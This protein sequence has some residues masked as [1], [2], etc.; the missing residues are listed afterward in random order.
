MTTVTIV[1]AGLMTGPMVNYFLDKCGYKIIMLDRYPELAEKKIR[2]RN[3][4]AIEWTPDKTEVLSKAVQKADFVISMLPKHLHIYVA[5]ACIKNKKNM[6]TSA[7]EIPELKV[8]HD[9]AKEKGILI[10]NELGEV[11][12]IDHYGTQLVLDRVRKKDGKVISLKSY[13]SSIPVMQDNPFSY[14]FAW[15]PKTFAVASQTESTYLLNGKKVKTPGN[16]LFEDPKTVK[17]KGLGT[18]ET[19]PNKDVTKYVK[20]FGLDENITFYRGLLRHPG[21]CKN[22]LNMLKLGLFKDRPDHDFSN[23]TY[24]KFMAFVIGKQ[25]AK[26]VEKEIKE[27]L[28]LEDDSFIKVLKWLGLL[29][30]EKIAIEKGSFVDVTLDKMIAK[31]SYKP[32]E[33]DM[34]MVHIEVIAENPEGEQFMETATLKVE[35]EPNGRESAISRAVALSVAIS[36][37]QFITGK[38]KATG[39]QMP[40]TLPE[41]C[42]PVLKEL[43]EY[44]FIF[45]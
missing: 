15:D 13:G 5:D 14:K 30:H 12:G 1:G 26:D 23:M 19:Y 7:Y 37:N 32:G 3:G 28:E 2:G 20:P 34:I 38:I 35:G 40:P 25:G 29:S 6:A 22:I 18:F 44:G 42:E 11:P 16:K 39:V 9:E 41:L 4:V 43:E 24:N 36:V 10:L 31:M 17:I 33:K 27:H 8:L 45:E 21:Y